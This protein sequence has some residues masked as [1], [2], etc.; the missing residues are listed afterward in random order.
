MSHHPRHQNIHFDGH[1]SAMKNRFQLCQSDRTRF[2]RYIKECGVSDFRFRHSYYHSL[3]RTRITCITTS[4][5][6]V[7]IDTLQVRRTSIQKH[8]CKK[9]LLRVIF[10]LIPEWMD[11]GR[12]NEGQRNS[13][14][15]LTASPDPRSAFDTKLV[16][17][18]RFCDS[19]MVSEMK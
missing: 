11:Y 8:I 7:M 18:S 6:N 4:F 10:P 1:L 14:M 13:R 5:L 9:L 16:F 15:I 3:S 2:Y 17:G 19:L 12:E